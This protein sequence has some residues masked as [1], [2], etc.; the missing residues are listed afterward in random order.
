MFCFN[1]LFQKRSLPLVVERVDERLMS[2]VS[3]LRPV[4][5]IQKIPGNLKYHLSFFKAIATL[6][7]NLIHLLK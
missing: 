5:N 4:L 7:T 1:F 2:G 6:R 3:Q